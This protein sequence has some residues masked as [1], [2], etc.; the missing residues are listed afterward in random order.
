[1][2]ITLWHWLCIGEFR[3]INRAMDRAFLR[4]NSIILCRSV[5]W[6]NFNFDLGL[7]DVFIFGLRSLT[8]GTHWSRCR[9]DLPGVLSLNKDI[10]VVFNRRILIL[11]TIYGVA[12]PLRLRGEEIHL[13]PWGPG[14]KRLAST[15]HGCGRWRKCPGHLHLRWFRLNSKGKFQAVEP[16]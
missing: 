10:F 5:H 11:L 7:D 9:H 13:I 6:I 2:K 1:M 3:D 15:K 16:R 14:R 4:T 8:H 12:E